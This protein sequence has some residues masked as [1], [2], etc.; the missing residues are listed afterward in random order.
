MNLRK[1]STSAYERLLVSR[2]FLFS[3][4]ILTN[5]FPVQSPGARQ[6]FFLSS[7]AFNSNMCVHT[8][9]VC[10]CNI[11]HWNH[12]SPWNCSNIFCLK[13]DLSKQNFPFVMLNSIESQYI[14]STKCVYSS[15]KHSSLSVCLLKSCHI[16]TCYIQLSAPRGLECDVEV[17]L[18]AVL[19]NAA[20]EEVSSYRPPATVDCSSANCRILASQIQSID[21]FQ[22]WYHRN[23]HCGW[24]Y[25]YA[26]CGR[27]WF[28]VMLLIL[29]S[30]A[31]SFLW[32][33]NFPNPTLK[34]S[35]WLTKEFS[36]YFAW[37]FESEKSYLHFPISFYLNICLIIPRLNFGIYSYVYGLK[38][39]PFVNYY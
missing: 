9:A 5:T 14:V 27:P 33:N 1:C 18:R 29:G 20:S 15:V 30:I 16:W 2:W 25:S 7:K 32:C 19:P 22:T 13:L 8:L 35:F 28:L 4:L 39:S 24:A 10:F 37:T 31:V 21:S 17:C 38:T 12:I 23:D 3:S 26:C 6:L 34:L 11:V 36:T